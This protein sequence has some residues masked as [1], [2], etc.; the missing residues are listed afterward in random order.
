MIRGC[1]HL[2][3]YIDDTGSAKLFVAK[4]P[5]KE[6]EIDQAFGIP[7]L[8]PQAPLST[9]IKN[10][11]TVVMFEHLRQQQQQQQMAAFQAMGNMV[12]N[13]NNMTAIGGINPPAFGLQHPGTTTTT[14]NAG[15][16][17]TP[18]SNYLASNGSGST[19]LGNATRSIGGNLGSP[20]MMVNKD[21][22]G[23]V[24]GPSTLSSPPTTTMDL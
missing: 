11:E 1:P 14:P 22:G 6:L 15:S 19:S 21:K 12:V 2:C 20:S 23:T 3:K 8:L 9:I 5:V 10:S 7:P 16:S 24:L 18:I 4:D 13:P 17:S